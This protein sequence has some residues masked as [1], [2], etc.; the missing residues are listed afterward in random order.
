MPVIS[1]N[2]DVPDLTLVKLLGI[3]IVK[4]LTGISLPV[5]VVLGVAVA[6]QLQ[7]CLLSGRAM[8]ERYVIIGDVV[9][10]MNFFLVQE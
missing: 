1:K 5:K 8:R 7:P 4:L 9:E 10:E 6:L 2:R 3:G